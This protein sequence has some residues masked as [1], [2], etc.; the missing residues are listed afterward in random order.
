MSYIKPK[1]YFQIAEQMALSY[2]RIRDA[3]NDGTA[4]VDITPSG[5]TDVT[6]IAS[7]YPAVTTN[8][9]D[10]AK[11]IVQQVVT[12]PDDNLDVDSSVLH[13]DARD[14]VGSIAYDL[15]KKF[16]D[17]GVTFTEAKAKSIAANYFSTALKALNAHVIART[18]LPPTVP[19]PPGRTATMTTINEYYEAYND[20][21]RAFGDTAETANEMGLFTWQADSTGDYFT[22]G[23]FSANFV[24]LS[25]QNNITINAEFQAITWA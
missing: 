19:Q 1:Q 5:W 8:A 2:S 14:P 25:A 10:F 22:G 13:S 17:F 9:N 21:P 18:P 12:E 20:D 3:L 15:G 6:D 7:D 16:G 24:E 23:Y 11:N 4:L